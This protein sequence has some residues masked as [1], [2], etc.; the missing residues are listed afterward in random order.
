MQSL[1]EYI[2]TSQTIRAIDS[3]KAGNY[4]AIVSAYREGLKPEVN[5]QRHEKMYKELVKLGFK[6]HIGVLTGVWEGVT[7]LSYYIEMPEGYDADDPRFV[8][9]IEALSRKYKQD[10]FIH[11]DRQDVMLQ[12]RS[13][14]AKRLGIM[15]TGSVRS[16]EKKY[17]GYS[18]DNKTGKAF[19]FV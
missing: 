1:Q 13:G 12:P 16:F 17:D 15:M 5:M 11:G 6:G 18:I 9:E 7:E 8:D 4:F 19:V 10:A 2:T 3:I 14:S